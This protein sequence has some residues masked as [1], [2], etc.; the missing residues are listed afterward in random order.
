[1]VFGIGKKRQQPSAQPENDALA[2]WVNQGEESSHSTPWREAKAEKRSPWW[3]VVRILIVLIAIAAVA[4]LVRTFVSSQ[5]AAPVVVETQA[6]LPDAEARALAE[7]FVESFYSWDSAVPQ[8]RKQNL[9]A[10]MPMNSSATSGLGWDGKGHQI[11]SEARAT[12]V[13]ITDDGLMHVSVVFRLV[14]FDV[15]GAALPPVWSQ[16]VVPISVEDDGTQVAIAG[17]PGLVPVDEPIES[18]TKT[19]EM[20]NAV[21]TDTKDYAQ[22]FFSALGAQEDV[23]AEAAPGNHIRGLAGAVELVRVDSWK[24]WAGDGHTREAVAVVI[25]RNSVS[26]FTAEYSVT[27]TK[28]TGGGQSKWLVSA[29]HGTAE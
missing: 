21:T 8:Q 7:R 26:E 6:P 20:D 23:N 29:I 9:S 14:A 17:M 13:E 4:A 16:A 3:W 12:T 18:T 5:T 27:L 10:D 19:P 28:I 24:V 15:D 22:S 1:M 2:A 11:A 25:W